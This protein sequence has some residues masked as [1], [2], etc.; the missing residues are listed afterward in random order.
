[1]FARMRTRDRAIGLVC[2]LAPQIGLACWTWYHWGNIVGPLTSEPVP[3]SWSALQSG[4]LGL[5]IDRE[6][7]LL[8]WAPI[9][10]LLPAAWGL[11]WSK[12]RHWLLPAASLFLVSAAWVQWWAGF[13]PAARFLVPLVPI[14]ALVGCNALHIPLVRHACV[15]L[16]VPQAFISGYGWHVPRA[17][18]PVGDG[19][20]RALVALV[21][22]FGGSDTFLP[23]LRASVPATARTAWTVAIVGIINAAA[24]IAATRVR[25][26]RPRA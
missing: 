2:F 18:W 25:G 7:G 16:L 26:S 11:G 15:V 24:W 4:S 17:L 19:H 20:N 3:F 9:Y 10:L 12:S 5:W 6:N 8:A 14:F 22:W 1:M 23:S 13:S 21:Q